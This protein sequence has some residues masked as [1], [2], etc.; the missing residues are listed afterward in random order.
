MHIDVYISNGIMFVLSFIKIGPLVSKIF[1]CV[2]KSGNEVDWLRDIVMFITNTITCNLSHDTEFWP[3]FSDTREDKA[4]VT[5][6]VTN[7]PIIQYKLSSFQDLE[8]NIF[9]NHA[10]TFLCWTLSP[11]WSSCSSY[12]F[13]KSEYRTV[14]TSKH[15]TCRYVKRFWR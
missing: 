9:S 8:V 2:F 11:L 5:A 6:I 4:A 1:M 15:Q 13:V 12:T 3:N 7:S 10:A 14:L